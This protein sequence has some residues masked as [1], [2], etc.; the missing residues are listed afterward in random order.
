MR[1]SADHDRQERTLDS[2]LASREASSGGRSLGGSSVSSGLGNGMRFAIAWRRAGCD[3]RP[4][5]VCSAGR[6]TRALAGR[7]V[8]RRV[9]RLRLEALRAVPQTPVTL[10][11]NTSPTTSIGDTEY[12]SA[13][14]SFGARGELEVRWR[15][16]RDPPPRRAAGE[17]RHRA[18]ALLDEGAA[19]ERPPARGRRRGHRRRRRD[20][21]ALGRKGGARRRDP[22]PARAG[23]DAG[24]HR[25]YPPS[26]TSPPCATRSTSSAATPPRSIP[27][28]RST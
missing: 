3:R 11:R 16:L 8:D 9:A 28:S 12:M 22:L 4:A 18:A 1:L 24:L 15:D 19:R 13:S 7:R 21:R 25:A 26:S 14:N 23:P 20:D 5:G 17:V 10:T 27:A 6:A 2:D